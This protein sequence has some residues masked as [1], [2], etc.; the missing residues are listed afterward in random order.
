MT[1]G[2][3]IQERLGDFEIIG[4]LGR[5]GMGVVYEARQV[6]LN[7]RVALKVISSPL[8]R[9]SKAEERFRREAEAAGRLHHTNI[10]PIYATGEDGGT[11]YYAMELVEG[12]SLQAVI[13]HLREERA[14]ERKD[15]GP[16]SNSSR[17]DG[18]STG[19]I[20]LSTLFRELPSWVDETFGGQA[21]SA[22]TATASSGSA[23]A[24]AA[25]SS[26]QSGVRYFDTIAGMLASVADALHHAHQHGVIHRDVKP[27]NLLLSP[28]GRLSINDFGL[29]RVLEQPGMTTSGEFVGSPL[30][31]SPEQIAAGRVPLDHRSDIFSLGSTLYEL[32]TLV[33]AFGGSGRDQVMAAILHKE[34]RRPRSIDRKVPADLETICLKALEKDCDRRYQTA[35]EVADDLRRFVDRFEIAAKRA[36]PVRR[37]AKWAR[38]RPAAAGLLLCLVVGV[39]V[40]L[41]LTR[42]LQR[43]DDAARTAQGE[44][45]VEQALVELFSGRFEHVE[46]H[47]NRAEAHDVVPGRLRVL[48]GAIALEGGD[49]DRAVV[50]LERAVAELPGSLAAHSLLARA[51]IGLL[52]FDDW[53]RTRGIIQRLEPVTQE[54][55]LYGATFSFG[56]KRRWG[57]GAACRVASADR[58]R[59][60]LASDRAVSRAAS[61]CQPPKDVHPRR[62]RRGS[63]A[64]GDSEEH[65]A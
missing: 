26:L 54:D 35:G 9:S 2:E 17:G 4:E 61:R 21:D 1:D 20:G 45:A 12:P 48:R 27:A 25:S 6:S 10:V 18:D 37:V 14:G 60:L 43:A 8:G 40:T 53:R 50:H 22:S 55:Y 5:G 47:L 16:V 38:R 63:P 33:P 65:A 15:V 51:Y 32:L 42:A 49:V 64:S 59:A 19:K 46:P 52:R 3:N 13:D 34:P 28:D 57:T 62:H 31:M 11:L 44:A 36:G 56:E 58:I 23:A 7:R 39:L 29:A 41:L 24:S 30:Y